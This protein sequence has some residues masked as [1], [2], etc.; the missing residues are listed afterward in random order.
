MI[1]HPY[2]H[3]HAHYILMII[4]KRLS[5]FDFEIYEVGHQKCLAVDEDVIS[6]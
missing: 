6:D 3:M 1:T 4:S 2:E 5:R